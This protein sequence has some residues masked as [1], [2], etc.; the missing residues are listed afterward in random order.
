MMA[1]TTNPAPKM[2]AMMRQYCLVAYQAVFRLPD[3]AHTVSG[4]IRI[5]P[6]TTANVLK[7]VSIP[8]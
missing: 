1:A 4:M 8:T 6:T 2:I 5:I 3:P 7:K